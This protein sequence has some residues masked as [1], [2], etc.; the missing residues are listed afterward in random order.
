MLKSLL[1]SL[2]LM[3]C[4][5]C[6]SPLTRAAEDVRPEKP[7]SAES[8]TS[9]EDDRYKALLRRLDSI[10][11]NLKAKQHIDDA[12]KAFD[13]KTQGQVSLISTGFTALGVMATVIGLLTAAFSFLTVKLFLVNIRKTQQELTKIQQEA[14]K[15][16]QEIQK[17]QQQVKEIQRDIEEARQEVHQTVTAAH[18]DYSKLQKMSKEISSPPALSAT[19]RQEAENAAT[20][21]VGTEVLRGKAVLAQQAKRW[22]EVREL[23]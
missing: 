5:T 15:N 4:L 20:Q 7:A 16:G 18:E 14:S 11:S 2:F 23:T 19:D 10:E 22:R 12:L 8:R 9:T 6:G 3:L 21:G 1:F 17:A 13:A